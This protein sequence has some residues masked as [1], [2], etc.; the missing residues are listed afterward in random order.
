[1]INY[2]FHSGKRLIFLAI[3]LVLLAA[4][5]TLHAPRMAAAADAPPSVVRVDEQ[6]LAGRWVRP[7]GGYILELK[8]VKKNGS[9]KAEYFNPSP[10]KVFSAKWSRKAGLL[11]VYVEL[12]DVNYPGSKYNLQYDA[13]SDRLMG[14]YFQAVQGETYDVEF[15]REI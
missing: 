3:L 5:I 13:A 14:T 12:R 15:L 8:D 11:N 2:C 10:I 1:M 7:D 4:F 9:L 6:R